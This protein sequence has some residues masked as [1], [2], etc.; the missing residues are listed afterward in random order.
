MDYD[1]AIVGGG[2]AGL[3]CAL[4]AIRKNMR[5]VVFEGRAW[6]GAINNTPS[7]QNYLGFESIQGVE[8]G[9][10]MRKHVESYGE[11]QL[12][13]E[14]VSSIAKK[15][16]GFT[17][18]TADGKQ[19]QAKTIVLATG[20]AYRNLGVPGEKEFAGKGVSYCVTCDAPLFK[21]KTVAV[22]G[23]GNTA[24]TSAITLAEVASKVYL[25]NR[26]PEFTGEAELIE[27]VKAKGVTC[28][29]NK[30]TLKI[31]GGKF[32]KNV[33]LQ[34]SKTNEEE[35]LQVQGVFINVGVVPV[36]T[37]ATAIGVELMPNGFVKTRLKQE[38]NVPG[39]FA[40]GDCTGKWLQVVE[41][42][43][44]GALAAN[45]AFE[46]VKNAKAVVDYKH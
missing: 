6:G 44:E 1:I 38:T 3:A 18:T 33:T 42:V 29:F 9:Q 10:A 46:F 28:L 17:L 23:G 39:V 31:E 13:D 34:D 32:V 22:I 12:L 30:N 7:I 41:A 37:L 21:G 24:L 25:I 16:D 14:Q 26:G 35:T 8:L 27:K 5:T 15:A 40:A 45:S 11:A 36:N 2:P 20:S 19:R 4:Y 43:A